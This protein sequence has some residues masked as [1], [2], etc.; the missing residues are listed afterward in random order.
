MRIVCPAKLHLSFAVCL[1]SEKPCLTICSCL[2]PVPLNRLSG[3]GEVHAGTGHELAFSFATCRCQKWRATGG[4]LPRGGG[5]PCLGGG[6]ARVQS[7]ARDT[8]HG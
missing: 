8:I 6:R 4:G 2:S 7:A 3:V 5:A 1:A